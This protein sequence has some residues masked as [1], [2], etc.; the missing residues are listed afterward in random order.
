[1]T[2]QNYCMVNEQTN[3]CDNVVVWDGD[4]NTWTPPAGYLMLVQETT[5]AKNWVWNFNTEV[6]ELVV[7]GLGGIDYTWDGTYLVTTEPEPPAPIQPVVD[8]AQTL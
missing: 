1:M 7:D 6:W 2:N 5:P 8:G 3:I 4:T